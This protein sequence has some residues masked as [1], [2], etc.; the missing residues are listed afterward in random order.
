MPAR[1]HILGVGQTRSMAR[2]ARTPLREATLRIVRD[3]DCERRWKRSRREAAQPFPRCLGDVRDRRRTA[4]RRS[5][6]S[7][8]ATPADRSSPAR[9]S[10]PCSS[11][12]SAGP[13]SAARTGCPTVGEETST[14]HRVPDRRGAR[15][16]AGP[17]RPDPRYAQ[18]R[19]ADLRDC[20]PGASRPSRSRSAG[21]GAR[22]ARTATSSSTVSGSART[23]RTE[24][25][26]RELL[27]CQALGWNAG[28]RTTTPLR[29]S[30]RQGIGAR[31]FTKPGVASTR[32]SQARSRAY[33]RGRRPRRPRNARR[34]GARCRR[35]CSR[36]RR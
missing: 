6:P 22:V 7:A 15:V 16:G 33:S 3:A 18:R 25:D 17:G 28:G 9:S 14:Y 36:R 24:K 31:S 30:K 34:R 27:S 29:E 35:P 10:G 26:R 1:V 12:S 11:G 20:R 8:P 4:A 19:D 5:I 32:S 13:A 23:R 2:P 21:G